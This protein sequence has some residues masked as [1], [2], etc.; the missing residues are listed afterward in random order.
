MERVEPVQ[1]VPRFIDDAKY[2]RARLQKV[3]HF[4][5][6]QAWPRVQKIHDRSCFKPTFWISASGDSP[7]VMIWDRW[8]AEQHPDV[9]HNSVTD[10]FTDPK[11][12]L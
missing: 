2:H 7:D 1:A 11:W 8:R 5:L 6:L 3:P 9:F 12:L 4:L 10:G